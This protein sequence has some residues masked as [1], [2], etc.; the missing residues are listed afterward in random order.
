MLAQRNQLRLRL[1]RSGPR[2]RQSA[3]RYEGRVLGAIALGRAIFAPCLAK[4][5]AERSAHRQLAGSDAGIRNAPSPGSGRRSTEAVSGV[6]VI[7]RFW[8]RDQNSC[9]SRARPQAARDKE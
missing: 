1:V 9:G 7:F 3:E 5:L 2:N 8:S 6:P 4:L